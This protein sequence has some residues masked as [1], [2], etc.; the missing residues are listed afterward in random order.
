MLGYKLGWMFGDVFATRTTKKYSNYKIC[1]LRFKRVVSVRSHHSW[2]LQ[3]S[4]VASSPNCFSLLIFKI[5]ELSVF[6]KIHPTYFTFKFFIS[7][8]STYS[9]NVSG[10]SYAVQYC[11]NILSMIMMVSRYKLIHQTTAFPRTDRQFI[12][13]WRQHR[14]RPRLTSRLTSFTQVWN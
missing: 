9:T 10:E 5:T 6:L 13:L 4:P 3:K 11:H 14:V 2:S 1:F 8:T 12:S 7:S